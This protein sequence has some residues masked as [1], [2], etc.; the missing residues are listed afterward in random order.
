MMRTIGRTLIFVVACACA[1]ASVSYGQ[2]VAKATEVKKWEYKVLDKS[3]VFAEY[4][5][6]LKEKKETAANAF[7]K[8]LNRLGAQGWELVC[9]SNGQSYILKRPKSK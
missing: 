2:D 5:K 1:S 4:H 7:E 8:I 9:V 6:T 3:D